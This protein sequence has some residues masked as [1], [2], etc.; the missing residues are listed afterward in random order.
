M[1]DYVGRFGDHE[2]FDIAETLQKWKK[3]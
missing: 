2:Y 3:L 1:E